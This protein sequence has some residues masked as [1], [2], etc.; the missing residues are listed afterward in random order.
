MKDY[1]KLTEVAQDLKIAEI[2]IWALVRKHVIPSRIS[3]NVLE[4]ETGKMQKWI[5]DNPDLLQEWKEKFEQA[6]KTRYLFV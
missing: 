2:H 6:E 5:K 3:G 4:I 1:K